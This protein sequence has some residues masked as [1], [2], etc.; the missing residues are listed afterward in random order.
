M[1]HN[2]KNGIRF[3]NNHTSEYGCKI[4][5]LLILIF[6]ISGK[7]YSHDPIKKGQF[8]LTK[9]NVIVSVNRQDWFDKVV[10]D[11]LVNDGGVQ[12]NNP[13]NLFL[14]T[15]LFRYG[16][17]SDRPVLDSILGERSIGYF[18]EF[19]HWY[20]D[21]DESSRLKSSKCLFFNEKNEFE[22]ITQIRTYNENGQ[23][24]KYLIRQPWENFMLTGYGD[25]SAIDYRIEDY[26]YE[27]GNLIQK[28]ITDN[29][30]APSNI[31]ISKYLYSYND[32]NQL[33]HATE[34]SELADSEIDYLYNP[35]GELEYEVHEDA[36]KKYFVSNSISLVKYQYQYTDSTKITINCYA[37]LSA[38]LE[39]S[40]YDTVSSWVYKKYSF[41]TFDSLE[42]RTS[43][44][45]SYW[46]GNTGIT[47]NF[48][49]AEFKYPESN[50]YHASY[51][52]WV[53]TADSGS[54]NESARIDNTYDADDNL[55]QYTKTYYDERT[56]SWAIEEQKNYYYSYQPKSITT[57]N[58]KSSQLSIF[59]NPAVDHITISNL[60]ENAVNYR[61]YNSFGELVESGR[62]EN[63]TLTVA[64][65]KPGIYIIKTENKN[66][67]YS[68]RF[69][70]Y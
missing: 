35:N 6:L 50:T 70:K 36:H 9:E 28:T 60:H 62:I 8:I 61:L 59:P 10:E 25:S 12:L 27:Q 7:I 24:M 15:D 2:F 37:D 41:E 32:K 39:R 69:V 16:S 68:G 40:Q 66:S 19:D 51:F 47:L 13:D 30:S 26:V 20:F 14:H 22:N 67:G 23:I 64:H 29:S 58:M 3:V 44:K 21:Y 43:V 63:P 34:N 1:K 52:N 57:V 49:K 11:V 54:W 55:I 53:S 5:L 17:S 38:L 4:T 45:T 31:R 42:R 33:I 46:D 56:D 48:S 18:K 65:L